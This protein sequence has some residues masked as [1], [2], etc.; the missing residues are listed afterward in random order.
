MALNKKELSRPGLLEHHE[1]YPVDSFNEI[2]VP[3]VDI[4]AIEVGAETLLTEWSARTFDRKLFL[5]LLRA[6]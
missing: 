6:F 5:L 2:L 3:L 1:I 4:K